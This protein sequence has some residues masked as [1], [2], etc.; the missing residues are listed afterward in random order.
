MVRRPKTR[1][2]VVL[3]L[4]GLAIGAVTSEI[5]IRLLFPQ[6]LSPL[7]TWAVTRDY[8]PGMI[9]SDPTIGWVLSPGFKGTHVR[10]TQVEINSIGLRDHEVGEKGCAELRILSLGDSYAFGYGVE[11]EETY[12]KVL[13][14]LFR[15]HFEGADISVINGGVIAYD[16]NQMIMEFDRLA[17][18]IDPDFVL[19]TFVAGNDVWE[20]VMFEERLKQRVSSPVG[21]VGRNSHFMR[22]F[23]RVSF[24]PRFFLGNRL[25]ANV[26]HTIRLLEE[27]EKRFMTAN[28]PYLILIIPARHQ[29]RPSVHRGSA[30]LD[31]FGAHA[32]IHRQNTQIKLHL[33]QTDA[34]YLDLFPTL[35][36][37]ERNEP[38]YFD[39][40]PHTN[41]LGHQIMA[42]A[43]FE[44]LEPTIGDLVKGV[45]EKKAV[46][47]N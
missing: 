23:L 2:F 36:E 9:V 6:T 41:E 34:P 4:F 40:D 24:G 14:E 22:L 27:L 28:V 35:M 32:Y 43:I 25:E 7:L 3:V 8:A 31:A 19:A 15:D 39:N 13:M 21:F 5:V 11:L 45:S 16:T 33:E 1:V 18:H 17:E 12:A 26:A 46:V 10:D 29:V 47:G 30:L 44:R 20:N 38:V 42:E 37:R